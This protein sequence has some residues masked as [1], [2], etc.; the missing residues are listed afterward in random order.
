M[1]GCSSACSREV[2]W[3]SPGL[4]GREAALDRG[5]VDAAHC[6]PSVIMRGKRKIRKKLLMNAN[7]AISQP[8][9]PWSKLKAAVAYI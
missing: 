9:S 2:A 8:L 7:S 5:G 4:D 3:N 6:L 1:K